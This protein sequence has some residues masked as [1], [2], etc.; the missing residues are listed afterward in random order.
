MTSSGMTKI[1]ASNVKA[2]IH[3]ARDAQEPPH[4]LTG[5]FERVADVLRE[6]PGLLPTAAE[7]RRHLGVK[8]PYVPWDEET[9]FV[10]Y[11]CEM[12][13][14]ALMKAINDGAAKAGLGM[15]FT[16]AE[17]GEMANAAYDLPPPP[18]LPSG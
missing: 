11:G 2:L 12:S 16:E 14:A 13:L 18:P 4:G 9:D 6:D 1:T 7:V 10:L 17:V 3:A 15:I 8:T 5:L